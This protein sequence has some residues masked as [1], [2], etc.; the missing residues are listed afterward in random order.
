M[1]FKVVDNVASPVGDDVRPGAHPFSRLVHKGLDR[2][3]A[4]SIAI[5][6]LAHADCNGVSLVR[7]HV[8]EGVR[9]RHLGANILIFPIDKGYKRAVDVKTMGAQLRE[10]VQDWILVE[11]RFLLETNRQLQREGGC[12]EIAGDGTRR[13]SKACS[14]E[15]NVNVARA[16]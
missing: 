8:D 9:S 14:T 6:N 1:R 3:G 5:P 7:L 15:S 11:Y 2:G 12:R 10:S 16:E 13:V 4:H